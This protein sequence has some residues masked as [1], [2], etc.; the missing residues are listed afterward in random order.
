M[1]TFAV[2]LP[3]ASRARPVLD[4]GDRADQPKPQAQKAHEATKKPHVVK[5][6]RPASQRRARKNTGTPN[7]LP[8]NASRSRRRHSAAAQG[9]RRPAD[10]RSGAGEGSHRSRAQGQDRRGD[11]HAEQDRGPG[12]AEARRVVHPAPL[13]RRPRLSAATRRS[14]PP[15]RNGR[16]RRCCAGAPR[17]GCG[18]SAAMR[19]RFAAS[20][21][22]GRPAPRASWR[23]RACCSPTA[24]ATARPAGAR[25]MAIG[26][27]VGAPRE[28]RVR[29]VPRP[30]HPR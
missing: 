23:W 24:I 4:G 12:G 2:L 7:M 9:G 18:R 27:I 20:P 13:R 30:S 26:R 21:A 6:A 22:T 11:R 15:I 5:E 14:S 17:R 29:D 10:R 8:R 19:R 25:R 16:A 28:R 3:H 1:L